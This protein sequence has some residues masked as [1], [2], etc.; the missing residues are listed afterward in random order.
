MP[1]LENEELPF[2]AGESPFHIKGVALRGYVDY[3]ERRVSGGMKSVLAE[4]RTPELKRFFEQP[5]L[6]ASWYDVFPL[7]P[8]GHVCAKLLNLPFPEYLR[9]RA[10]DQAE[11]DIRGVYKL[12]LKIASPDAVARR[13]LKLSMQQYDFGSVSGKMVKSGHVESVRSGVPAILVP[14]LASLIDGYPRY[15]L[16]MA[17]AKNLRIVVRPAVPTGTEHGLPVVDMPVDFF[18][19]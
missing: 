3:V 17:G 5:F 19:D 16:A 7:V 4:F 18:W 12:M 10:R 15:V 11:R 14:W 6:A 2:P 8:A 13:F 1:N 9:I